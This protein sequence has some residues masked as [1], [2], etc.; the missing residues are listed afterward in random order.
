METLYDMETALDAK[1]KVLLGFDFDRV[2]VYE[3][4]GKGVLQGFREVRS[5]LSRH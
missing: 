2:L 5:R 4:V 3:G 1:K